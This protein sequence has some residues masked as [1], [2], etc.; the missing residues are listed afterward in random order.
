VLQEARENNI[1]VLVLSPLDA[2]PRQVEV[3]ITTRGELEQIDFNRGR[4]ILAEETSNPVAKARQ[5]LEGGS[6]KGVIVGID[7]GKTPGIAVVADNR[8]VEVYKT[9]QRET[10]SVVRQIIENYGRQKVLVRIGGGAGLH[11]VH[12]LNQIAEFAA[13]EV[14][15]ETHTTPHVGKGL[16]N[17]ADII[18]AINIALTAGKPAK[19]VSIK[20]TQGD[21]RVIQEQSRRYTGGRATISKALA[22]KVATGA[23]TLEEAVQQHQRP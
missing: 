19:P 21:I 1:E 9:S 2:I 4:M 3:V 6:F 20:P 23:L 7:P 13:V 17:T 22:R 11:S 18:A 10:C 5:M 12:L 15:D 14:V 8:V 16:N